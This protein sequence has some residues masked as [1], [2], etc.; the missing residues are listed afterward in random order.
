MS[1]LGS[2]G[3]YKGALSKGVLRMRGLCEWRA[4]EKRT[5]T[6]KEPFY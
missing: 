5:F 6:N 2:L 3:V 4:Y 1:T